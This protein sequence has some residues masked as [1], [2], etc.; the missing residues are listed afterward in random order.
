ML[1]LRER[2][3]DVCVRVQSEKQRERGAVDLHVGIPRW[4]ACVFNQLILGT[5]N[6][7]TFL[8][9]MLLI[10]HYCNVDLDL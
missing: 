4:R 7:S 1:T 3:P 10:V 5:C 8:S 6:S 9:S 2:K